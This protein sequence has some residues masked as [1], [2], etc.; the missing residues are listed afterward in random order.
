[1]ASELE[2]DLRE[3][4]GA[5]VVARPPWY[6]RVARALA[7]R[8]L[9][10]GTRLLEES[11]RFGLLDV[12]VEYPLEQH[13]RLRVPIWRPC[14][15]W[16]RS[17]VL[18]YE[19][20]FMRLFSGCVGA[21]GAHT[22]LIDCGADIGT[23]SAHLRARCINVARV[24][25][26]E[27]NPCAYRVLEANLRQLGCAAEA[28]HAAV[29]DFSGRGRMMS[30]SNDL[31][32]HAMFL[33]EADEGDVS[34]QRIDDLNLPAGLPLA[35]KIDV[36]GGELRVVNGAATTIAAASRVAIAFEAHPLVA[37]RNGTD[38]ATVMRRLREL[39]SDL[40]FQIDT[41]PARTL[42]PE[43]EVFEQVAPDDVYNIVAVS[44]A[45]ET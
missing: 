6:F 30:P 41:V 22:T 34:V 2:L 29:S 35:L 24:I 33:A 44:S 32:A 9:R 7:R 42:D 39:R 43:R 36:E 26:F 17:D 40:T 13:V 38:P 45:V 25:A 23:V 20:S 5:R 12:L 28:R 19:A 31:S 27:P 10:G 37:K 8:K 15:S 16:D 11:R 4:S 3:V 14:N 18:T 1:M 21:L